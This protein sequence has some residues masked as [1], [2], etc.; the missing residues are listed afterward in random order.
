MTH[1]TFLADIELLRFLQRHVL[2]LA[3]Y[4]I[5][6]ALASEPQRAWTLDAIAD[7]TG[8]APEAVRPHL[9]D[10]VGDGLVVLHARNGHVRYALTPDA[11]TRQ[12]I[13]A[14]FPRVR[15]PYHTA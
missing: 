15:S 2:G 5:I 6:N 1:K 12:R 9:A 7:R 10:L 8:R 13:L 4:R 14:L 11:R 3:K